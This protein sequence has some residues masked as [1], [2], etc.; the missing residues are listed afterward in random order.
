MKELL[1]K[2]ILKIIIITAVFASASALV[3]IFALPD[4]YFQAL[5]F[6]FVI[7]PGVSVAVYILLMRT[8]NKKQ[9][10]FNVSFMLS[11]VVKMVIYAAF[12]AIVLWA[13]NEN[14]KTF[15][16]YVLLAYILYT[17]FDTRAIVKDMQ[18]ITK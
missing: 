15:I 17:V 3:F 5:P 16:V 11:F 14:Y 12:V 13:D 2:F 7:F 1:K 9:E 6:V 18:K 8:V 10:Q 4:N